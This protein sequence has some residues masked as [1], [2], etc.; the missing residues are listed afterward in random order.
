M[1][2]GKYRI[3]IVDDEANIRPGLAKALRG[4]ADEIATAKDGRE[5]LSL[6][7]HVHHQLV[8]TD[9]KMS[10]AFSGLEL[11]KELKHECPDTLVLVMTAYGTIE[12]AVEAMRQGAFDYVSKPVI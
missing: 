8:I 9:L 3:L 6:F 1:S 5:A 12:T 4:E 11:T 10:G 7:R 2:D